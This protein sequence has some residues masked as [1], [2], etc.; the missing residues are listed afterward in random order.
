MSEP[1]ISVLRRRLTF[2]TMA[3]FGVGEVAYQVHS[4]GMNLLLLFFYQQV[5]GLSGTLT[6]VA[7]MISM[8]VDAVTDPIIG[9]WSDRIKSR[10]GRRHPLILASSV[11]LAV[12]FVLLFSPPAEMS[13]LGKFLWLSIFAVLVRFSVT[14]YYIP[15]MALGAEMAPDYNQ[16]ST[17][18]AYNGL[19]GAVTA[20]CTHFLIYIFVFPTTE[21]FDPGTLN[22]AGY[23][24]FAWVGAIVIIGAL[25]FCV[26]G[27]RR[28]IPHLRKV[29]DKTRL[30]L[31]E[32]LGDMLSI[33]NNRN[34]FILFIASFLMAIHGAVQQVFEP[35]IVLHFWEF[36][37]EEY[38]WLGLFML[39]AFPIG[40]FLTPIMTRRLD[41]KYTLIVVTVIG[42]IAPNTLIG[43]RLLEVSWF[44]SNE[45]DWVLFLFFATNYVAMIVA[46]IGGATIYSMFADIADEH[47]LKTSKRR[48]GSVYAARAFASKA[49]T[50]VGTFVG[51]VL[52][53]VIN[54]PQS[55]EAGTV[56]STVIWQLGF[57]SG[58][59]ISAVALLGVGLFFYYDLGRDRHA[60]I[61][62]SLAR[63]D[64][65]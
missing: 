59:A 36:K 15:H 38:G 62:K 31:A 11:P 18:F 44:P 20:A 30:T 40:F 25:V 10:F 29:E 47:D 24:T 2:P 22:P 17:L 1:Q 37:T 26:W 7:L 34:F 60:E 49:L 6:G 57:V 58:P 5:V 52:L 27:T 56:S 46:P 54:F 65:P 23:P 9:G 45:S 43:L 35:Y 39:S 63:R 33:F 14:L 3:A 28:E 48:E 12:S 51:G 41:K 61:I 4:Q 55:A 13:E 50:G 42:V 64:H 16:R 32:I 19:I 21:E 8:A 53:D